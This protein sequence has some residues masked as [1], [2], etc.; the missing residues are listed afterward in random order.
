MELSPYAVEDFSE[1]SRLKY[2]RNGLQIEI[3]GNA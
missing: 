3:G 2:F 1:G